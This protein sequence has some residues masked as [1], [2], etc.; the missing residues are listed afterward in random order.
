[1]AVF[2]GQAAGY[3]S[4]YTTPV[5][6]FVDSVETALAF[7]LFQPAPGSLV[8]DA[9]CGTGNFCLKLARQ[10]YRVTG[11]DLAEEMLAA[12]KV[13]A[14]ASGLPIDFRLMDV[15][16]LTYPDCHFDAVFSMAM[17]EFIPDPGAA[18]RE[19]FRVLRPGGL[20][21]IGT[22]NR[23]SRWGELYTSAEYRQNS[24]F[25]YA[26]L[27]TRAELAAL[28]PAHLIGSGECL[29]VPPG[30]DPEEYNPEKEAAYGVTER[31]G[32]IGLLWKKPEQP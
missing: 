25:K 23:D 13:K 15:T 19:L 28:D 1:M 9:G 7:S 20:L 14:A 30:L 32:F 6:Q 17:F 10:G 21:F 26:T 8:L 12:A 4:W 11:V 31:G 27:K 5:G 16:A 22:I 24:V 29:F 2:N 3:D 18:F